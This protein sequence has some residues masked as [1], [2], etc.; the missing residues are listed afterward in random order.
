MIQ[1]QSF[2]KRTYQTFRYELAARA[3]R[4]ASRSI[5]LGKSAFFLPS[6]ILAPESIRILSISPHPDD[7]VLAIGGMLAGHACR[8]AET[9]SLVLTNGNRGNS[10]TSI[11]FKLAAARRRETEAAASILK[12]TYLHFW[13]LDD[14]QLTCNSDLVDR[15]ALQ[16]ST[17]LPEMIY[18]PFPIDYHYDHLASTRLVLSALRRLNVSIPLRCYECIIPLIP[19]R[20]CDVS[21]WIELKREAVRCFVTQNQVTNYEYTIVEGLNKLRTH[22]LLKGRGYAEGV[23]ETDP[24]SLQ[25]IFAALT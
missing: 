17:F 9:M 12:I 22:G 13:D 25:S 7:D 20:I 2:F 16:I 8:N 10:N 18:L 4:V 24:Q 23:F 11:D 1:K 3:M 21:A 14:G 15:M 5:K 6:L 19:N